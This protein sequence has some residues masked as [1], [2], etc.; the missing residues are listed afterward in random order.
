[1]PNPSKYEFC[2]RGFILKNLT[3]G[4]VLR[5]RTVRDV[6]RVG[7][8]SITFRHRI[9]VDTELLHPRDECSSFQS[10]AVGSAIWTANTT[11]RF[12][13]SAND[14]I[15]I[16]FGENTPHGPASRRSCAYVLIGWRGYCMRVYLCNRHLQ[17][18]PRGQDH[19][20]LDYILQFPNV[21]GPTILGQSIH[22]LRGDAFNRPVHWAGSARRRV[23][24]ARAA[25][26][27]PFSWPKSSRS[28]NPLGMAAQFSFTKVFERRG[29]RLWMARAINSFPVPV[30]P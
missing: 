28:S 14:L 30:S 10:E 7:V 21:T 24:W 4:R 23:C 13:E 8:R 5:R 22:R 18:W 26:N 11:T 20:P 2:T 19:S 16:D 6:G 1:M 29:L 12:L 15:A 9:R 27:A 17:R 3:R 25:V